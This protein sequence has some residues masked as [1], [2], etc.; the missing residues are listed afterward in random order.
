MAIL[1]KLKYDLYHQHPPRRIGLKPQDLCYNE[2]FESA[3]ILDSADQL[4]QVCSTARDFDHLKELL[5]GTLISNYSLEILR[6]SNVLIQ[7]ISNARLTPLLTAIIINRILKGQVRSCFE[8]GVFRELYR[9]SLASA[10]AS[11]NLQINHLL[12]NTG[13]GLYIPIRTSLS[14]WRN[15]FRE[16][17]LEFYRTAGVYEDF[18]RIIAEHKRISRYRHN[19]G[20]AQRINLS[21]AQDRNIVNI[22]SL[23]DDSYIILSNDLHLLYIQGNRYLMPHSMLLETYNKLSELS[24]TL[25]LTHMQSGTNFPSNH[26]ETTFEFLQVMCTSVLSRYKYSGPAYN[27][28]LDNKGFLLLKTIEA[29]SAGILIERADK[30]KDWDNTL[31]NTTMWK[32]LLDEGIVYDRQLTD[33]EL[34]KVWMKMNMSQIAESAGLVKLFGHPT[35]EVVNGVDKLNNRVHANLVIDP[36]RVKLCSYILKRDLCLNFY[37]VHGRFPLLEMPSS[38]DRNLSHM[39]LRRINP[40]TDEGHTLLSKIPIE[41]WGSIVF[42]KNAEFDRVENQLFLLKDKALGLTRSK[43]LTQVLCDVVTKE[44]IRPY[45]SQVN[46]RALLMYLFT[47]SCANDF[48]N[49]LDRYIQDDS[50]G[51]YVLD[52][53][54]VKLTAKEL[55]LKAE[56]RYFGASPYVERNRRIVQELNVMTFLD[57]Y[58]PEQLLT[59]SELGVMKKLVSFRQ[60]HLL[61]PDAYVFNIS[62]D[63]SKWN[64]NFRSEVIDTVAD[65]ILGKWYHTPIYGKTMKAFHNML[66]YYTDK[67]HT[68][69]WVGQLGGIEG[70]NQATW[71]YVFLGGVKSAIEELGYNYHVSVKGDDVRAAIIVPKSAMTDK[72]FNTVRG[73]LLKT[74]SELC[75]QMGWQ[76][77]PNE[78]FVSLSLVCTSKQYQVNDTWLPSG[79]KKAMKAESLANLIFPTLEDQVASVFSIIHSSCSQSTAVLPSFAVASIIAARLIWREVWSI[80]GC[81]CTE[82]SMMLCWPQIIGGP[83]ALPLQTFFVR[84]ENDM[85]SASLSLLRYITNGISERDIE[86]P[87]T[88]NLTELQ[89]LCYRILIQP[90]EKSPNYHLLL[91]DPYSVCIASPARPSAVLK[92]QLRASLKKTVKNVEIREL[93]TSEAEAQK[94]ALALTLLSMVPY[95]PK[96]ATAIWECAPDYL[97]EE[98]CAKFLQSSTVLQY[99]AMSSRGG[100]PRLNQYRL[101]KKISAASKGRLEYWFSTLRSHD[102]PYDNRYL[103]SAVRDDWTNE[104]ICTTELVNRVR[105]HSWSKEFFGITYPS[106]VDQIYVFT[107]EDINQIFAPYPG[108]KSQKVYTYLSIPQKQIIPQLDTDSHHYSS[109][110]GN[111]IWLGSKTRSKMTYID[112]PQTVQSPSVKKIQKLLGLLRALESLGPELVKVISAILRLYTHIPLDHLLLLAPVRGHSNFHQRIEINSFSLVTM[113]NFRPNIAQIVRYSDTQQEIV[114]KDAHHRTINFAARYFMSMVLATFP[115]QSSEKLPPNYPDTILCTY[116]LVYNGRRLELC[117][118]CCAI[119]DNIR[120]DVRIH[121]HLTLYTVSSLALIRC[122]H[123]EESMIYDRLSHILEEAL[124]PRCST[125]LNELSEE[126]RINLAGQSLLGHA[127][128]NQKILMRN[129]RRAGISKLPKS[130]VLDTILP[131]L[132]LVPL[133]ASRVS[134]TYLR[135]VPIKVV[136]D[137]LLQQMLHDLVMWIYDDRFWYSHMCL[138][139]YVDLLER[140]YEPIFTLLGA[141]SLLSKLG[142]EITRSGYVNVAFYFKYG[143]DHKGYVAA[144]QFITYHMSV[145]RRWLFTETLIPFKYLPIQANQR[146]EL[147]QDLRRYTGGVNKMLTTIYARHASLT[148]NEHV[149]THQRGFAIT[150]RIVYLRTLPGSE[151]FPRLSISE[152]FD[153]L[154]RAEK[155]YVYRMIF[156]LTM[157]LVIQDEYLDDDI[158][159]HAVNNQITLTLTELVVE[160]MDAL[161]V[162]TAEEIAACRFW[163]Y[164]RTTI[165]FRMSNYNIEAWYNVTRTILDDFRADYMGVIRPIWD[166]LCAESSEMINC[167]ISIKMIIIDPQEAEDILH[168]HGLETID[169]QM[170]DE[171]DDEDEQVV[172]VPIRNMRHFRD[173]WLN[174]FTDIHIV[175]HIT[176]PVEQLIETVNATPPMIATRYDIP[177]CIDWVETT[178]VFGGINKAIS[179]YEELWNNRDMVVNYPQN[180]RMTVIVI[181]DGGG[182]VSSWVVKKFPHA[183]V[184]M[185]TLAVDPLTGETPSDSSVNDDPVEFTQTL[186]TPDEKCRI[187]HNIAFP[188]DITSEDV[189]RRVCS[190][191]LEQEYPVRLVICDADYPREAPEVHNTIMISALKCFERVCRSDTSL[192]IRSFDIWYAPTWLISCVIGCAFSDFVVHRS[193]ASRLSLC[194]KFLICGQP[195]RVSYIVSLL[196]LYTVGEL[197]IN[198]LNIPLA[199]INNYRSDIANFQA[200]ILVWVATGDAPVVS[201]WEEIVSMFRQGIRLSPPE[202]ILENNSIS[203]TGRFVLKSEFLSTMSREWSYVATEKC[204]NIQYLLQDYYRQREESIKIEKEFLIL[205]QLREVCKIGILSQLLHSWD[206]GLMHRRSWISH[207]INQFLYHT[208]FTIVLQAINHHTHDNGFIQFISFGRWILQLGRDNRRLSI[209][210]PLLDGIKIGVRIL[211]AYGL[212]LD[213]TM[214]LELYPWDVDEISTIAPTWCNLIEQQ[215]DDDRLRRLL[216]DINDFMSHNHVNMSCHVQFINEDGLYRASEI[217]VSQR[218]RQTEGPL[219]IPYFRSD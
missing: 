3:L 79:V 144:R 95:C 36:E 200:N 165:V 109:L 27:P 58:V 64:N 99:L 89:S 193:F 133:K 207:V 176:S 88:I 186:M 111:P 69:S 11:F 155:V 80:K 153:G 175:D 154:S 194:E 171:N 62:F 118:Y 76:L 164:L 167:L 211:A 65:E 116:H 178:R 55:E 78:S 136:Y 132:N 214:N 128:K 97:L 196:T 218:D 72:D 5:N 40:E 107:D 166:R 124:R 210:D 205:T 108:I 71:T 179:R 120:V 189:Q 204:C 143:Y 92:S 13:T 66:V 149:F 47:N 185:V 31:L 201:H 44:S 21:T 113:P 53:L 217:N 70:L 20:M 12:R 49:Y 87:S 135:N 191:A 93:L 112:T 52:Y 215:G 60:L 129:L 16:I 159:N 172:R 81:S 163:W 61:Y 63:F 85:L 152:I 203:G 146:S 184:V 28:T 82:I 115:L 6:K 190:I 130:Q 150:L 45:S 51:S 17:P 121:A 170:E 54:V 73:E 48:A 173:R 127:I 119:V 57:R 67:Q 24:V 8:P 104:T 195:L 131:G 43:V 39:I 188:G 156:L 37:R 38:I 100:S 168:T 96:I 105:C 162:R 90:L 134:P 56:G 50:W 158:V 4:Q 83:G 98:L 139:N 209:L 110:K 59:P 157:E 23:G 122:S 46:R 151:E 1:S 114:N 123:N 160:N 216:G 212:Y 94:E 161:P 102:I 177:R 174:Q 2:K 34:G 140:E 91:G 142:F 125:D 7:D 192:I 77:N 187:I 35:I 86:L 103:Y 180:S 183:Q 18:I 148:P 75:T 29:L 33:H 101:L 137:G 68:L 30:D 182:S 9:K 141:A 202:L 206:Y 14:K 208:S 74:I 145:F 213:L 181:G 22:P 15:K 147:Y 169:E 117:P 10:E 26:Y 198:H 126:E 199:L 19:T 219:L 138:D 106:L 84:G 41:S 197:N 25:L 42:S 32:S